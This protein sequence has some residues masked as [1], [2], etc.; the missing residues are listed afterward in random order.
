MKQLTFA[1]AAY[2]TK[3]K[4]TKR[5]RF[6]AE[7]EAVVPWAAMQ[8]LIE[9]HYPTAGPKGGRPP[10]GLAK[11]LRVWCLQQ[12]FALSDPGMEEA[13]YDNEAMRRFAGFELG[14]DAIPDETAILNFRR[15]LETH[16]LTEKLFALVRELLE[17]KGLLLNS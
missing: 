9:P 14:D 11:M 16:G 8:A 1:S 15:L 13:L 6:L 7:M 5:E 4:T 10:I 17:S 3:K 2:V 12:W